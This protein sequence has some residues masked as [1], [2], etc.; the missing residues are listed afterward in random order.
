MNKLRIT[1]LATAALAALSFGSPVIANAAGT[2]ITV[3]VAGH[4]TTVS[5]TE[6]VADLRDSML[7][8]LGFNVYK[9]H[10]TLN[11]KNLSEGSTLAKAGVTDGSALGIGRSFGS[12]AVQVYHAGGPSPLEA[13]RTLCVGAN[14]LKTAGNV[15]YEWNSGLVA[16]CDYENVWVHMSGYIAFENAGEHQLCINTDDGNKVTLDGATVID[17]WTDNGNTWDCSIE[18]FEAGV[19]K[20]ITVDFYENQG[21]AHVKLYADGNVISGDNFNSTP[22]FIFGDSNKISADSFSGSSLNASGKSAVAD[23]LAN[24]G[25]LSKINL[26]ASTYENNPQMSLA[27]A[28]SVR[29]QLKASGFTGTV[30]IQV[31]SGYQNSGIP[32]ESAVWLT[33]VAAG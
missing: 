5:N 28:K 16:G 23:W 27:L 3:T 33:P 20:A 10:L 21:G 24:A 26:L 22:N 9:H 15:Y 13:N 18:T 17:N 19:A 32:N 30:Q 4:E 12:L 8:D 1:A 2:D 31:R 25:S 14:V 6:T 11:G 29:K 7:G